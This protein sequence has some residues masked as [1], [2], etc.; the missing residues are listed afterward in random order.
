[1]PLLDAAWEARKDDPTL[2]VLSKRMLHLAMTMRSV[3]ADYFQYYYFRDEILRELQGKRTTRAEDLLAALPGYWEHYEEQ[4]RVDVPDARPEALA[5]RHPRAR[6]RD[7]RDERV[8][9]RHVRTPARQPAERR[10][11]AARLRRGR[12][13]GDVVHRRRQAACDRCRR[14]RCRTRCAA[15]CSSSPSTSTSPPRPRGRARAADGIRALAAN[16]MVPTLSVA[17]ELYD[18]MAYAHRA[19]LPERL[20]TLTADDR[21]TGGRAPLPRGRR[22]QL[23]DG[24]PRRRRRG[25]GPRA[26]P[27]GPRRHLRRRQ[28]RGRSRAPCS[29]RSTRRSA[30]AGAT[31]AGHS[32]PR[33]SGSRASTTRRTRSSGTSASRER[34]G[35]HGRLEHQERRVRVAARCSTAPVSGCRS[36]SARGR[37]WPRGRRTAAS[38]APDG[39]SST[40]SAD[41]ASATAALEGGVPAPG[42]ASAPRRRLTDAL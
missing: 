8:L 42:W 30:D 16:P 12:R 26:R 11:R 28:H 18:E 20:L 38:S 6:A 21:A 5:R 35:G 22:G 24:R 41:R 9:Q 10:R 2:D 23:Q 7:R 13:R 1:M 40:T 17:E 39:S 19:Y 33:P 15:S 25:H 27:R 32:R 29:A 37:P 34:L 3:P 31:A 14:S 36:P 4:S